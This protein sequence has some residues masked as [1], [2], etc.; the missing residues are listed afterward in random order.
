MDFL[1][2]VKAIIAS[3]SVVYLFYRFK[4]IYNLN[5]EAYPNIL[6]FAEHLGYSGWICLIAAFSIVSN[7]MGASTVGGFISLLYLWQRGY[8]FFRV[9]HAH[10]AETIQKT[11][12]E[13]HNEKWT[14]IVAA[15]YFSVYPSHCFI[16]EFLKNDVLAFD[17]KAFSIRNTFSVEPLLLSYIKSHEQKKR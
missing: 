17:H 4:G 3:G 13:L 6:V 10:I 5:V 7:W 9:E 15:D 16:V 11:V 12:I 8:E 14:F 2:G 1:E